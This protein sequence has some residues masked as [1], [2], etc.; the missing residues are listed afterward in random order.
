MLGISNVSGV[1]RERMITDEVNRSLGSTIANR[2][3]ALEE[4]QRAA[5]QINAMFGTNIKVSFREF[6]TLDE[7]ANPQSEDS[8]LNGEAA[9]EHKQQTQIILG[10]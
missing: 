3:S 1:K 5:D 8:L 10:N 2:L 7:N 4:R 9:E 6:D